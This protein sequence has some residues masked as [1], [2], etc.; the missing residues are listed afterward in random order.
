M[1]AKK[2]GM[3]RGRKERRKEERVGGDRE[4]EGERRKRESGRIKGD[5][6]LLTRKI[7]S[8]FEFT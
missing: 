8:L 1:L 4:K 3:E 5:I 2:G 7:T 6:I